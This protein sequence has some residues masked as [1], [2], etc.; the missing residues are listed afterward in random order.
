M[1]W[2]LTVKLPRVMLQQDACAC[3]QLLDWRVSVTLGEL[4]GHSDNIRQVC[5]ACSL[6]DW[7]AYPAVIFRS[8][9]PQT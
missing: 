3:L 9:V 6:R 2:P 5:L 1:C 7:T 8:A 4:R